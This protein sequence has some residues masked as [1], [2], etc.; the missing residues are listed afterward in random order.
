MEGKATFTLADAATG[1]TVKRLCEHNLVTDAVKRILA[2]PL[3]AL[4][5]KYSISD[6]L[7][8]VMPISEKLFGGIVL[9]GNNLDER[10]SNILPGR[11]FVPVATAGGAYSGTN[12]MRG[13]LNANET[14]ATEKGYHFTWDFG[15]DKANGTIKCAALTSRLF[16]N[17]GFSAEDRNSTILMDA[18]KPSDIGTATTLMLYAEGQ[19][20]GTFRE[21]THTFIRRNIDNS[22][23][24]VRIK[25]SDPSAVGLNDRHMLEQKSEPYYSVVVD[26]PINYCYEAKCYVDIATRTVYF[27]SDILRKDEDYRIDYFGVD[28]DSLAV[29]S[30]GT[31]KL[32]RSYTRNIA[33]ALYE[34][35]FYLATDAGVDVYSPSGELLKSYTLP[36]T[37]ILSWFCTVNG[38]LTLGNGMSLDYSLYNGKFY[39]SYNPQGVL[40]SYSEDISLPYCP[41]CSFYMNYNA[42]NKAN[43]DPYLGISA[44]YFATINNL[45]EPLEKTNAHTLK[46]T[47]DITN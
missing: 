32:A 13:T 4:T 15:T 21:M 11:D 34:G 10:A 23:T 28:L 12:I 44:N 37:S 36:T 33:A 42:S 39:P 31:Q 17:S 19:Y 8:S 22:I 41:V 30:Q 40:P 24:F 6:F 7:K 18:Q 26:C 3:Y 35:S 14:Y 2:P 45:S 27:F 46:I 1:K 20:L 9:M 25:S 16:G 5:L 29:V 38:V 47:Y 43:I